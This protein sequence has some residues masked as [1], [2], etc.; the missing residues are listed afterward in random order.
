M[1]YNIQ[2][3]WVSGLSPLPGSFCPQVRGGTPLLCEV[4]G[5]LLLHQESALHRHNMYS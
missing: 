2:N 5:P 4:T 1:V 3:Y